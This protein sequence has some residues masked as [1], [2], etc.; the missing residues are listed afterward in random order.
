[1]ALT[2][3]TQ[4]NQNGISNLAVGK[5]TTDAGAA[6]ATTF[7]LGFAPRR[8]FFVNITDRISDLWLEGMA[9]ASSLHVVAAGTQT[10]ETTNGITVSG[11]SFT[12]TAA[13]ILASKT[14]HWYAEA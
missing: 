8:V 1:M 14:F 7:T 2:V 4:T 12:V 3:N 6:A 13:T 5:V 10:L 9:A 11:N